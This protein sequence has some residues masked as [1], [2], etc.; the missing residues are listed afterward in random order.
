MVR[1][2]LV[3]DN[4]Y[5]DKCQEP[6]GRMKV[7]SVHNIRSIPKVHSKAGL[8]LD[9]SHSE[10]TSWILKFCRVRH[11]INPQMQMT[12]DLANQSS[13]KGLLQNSA[14]IHCTVLQSFTT[15]HGPEQQ[16]IV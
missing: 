14:Y 6:A 8:D 10:S 9:Q 2:L 3:Y 5:K 1:Y 13:A 11:T 16:P 4:P 7:S 12:R 15:L